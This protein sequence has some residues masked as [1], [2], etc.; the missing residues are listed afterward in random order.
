MMKVE[1]LEIARTASYETPANTLV[2]RITLKGDSGS[3]TITLSNGALMSIFNIIR[4][5]V[6]STARS[7][8]EMTN[9]AI[10]D[11]ADESPMLEMADAVIDTSFTPHV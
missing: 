11:A 3:Q 4:Q 1:R 2:G 8:A 6:L 5:E 9:R 7:N 10:Q